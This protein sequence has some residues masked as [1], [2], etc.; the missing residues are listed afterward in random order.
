[1]TGEAT[2]CPCLDHRQRC[3]PTIIRHSTHSSCRA[4]GCGVR[5]CGTCTGNVPPLIFRLDGKGYTFRDLARLATLTLLACVEI[6]ETHEACRRLSLVL[7]L[8]C[9]VRDILDALGSSMTYRPCQV[10]VLRRQR[11]VVGKG[12]ISPLQYWPRVE[13]VS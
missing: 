11:F 1:M 5:Q 8:H 6:P 7:L 13:Q 12:H 9:S 3:F 10:V 2:A 4:S